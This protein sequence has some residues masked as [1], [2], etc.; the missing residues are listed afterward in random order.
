MKVLIV[1][2]TDIKRKVL[3]DFIATNYANSDIVEAV[4]FQDGVDKL[5]YGP[6]D[7]VL[8]DMTMPTYNI[9]SEDAGGKKRPF[10]GREIISKMFRRKLHYP[11]IVVTRFDVFPDE[12]CNIT[13]Q[14]LHSQLT[15]EYSSVYK[16]YVFYDQ[17]KT[18]WINDL[19]DK[20]NNILK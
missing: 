3:S 12:H 19:A 7:I 15:D 5:K 11:V 8:L 10:A 2:D 16:G 4:S 18:G 14:E 20:I 17:V 9:T 1:E 13:L 6:Y